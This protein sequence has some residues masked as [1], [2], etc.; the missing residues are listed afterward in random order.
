MRLFLP[1]AAALL[2]ASPTMFS[3][4]QAQGS[5]SITGP[6]L[7]SRKRRANSDSKSNASSEEKRGLDLIR[8][9]NEE[10]LRY[11]QLTTADENSLV[12]TPG[13]TLAGAEVPTEAPLVPSE[14]IVDVDITCTLGGSG[15]PCESLTAPPLGICVP[16]D[17]SDLS[18]VTFEFQSTPCAG[19]DNDQGTDAV[20]TDVGPGVPPSGADVSIVCE[21]NAEMSAI[22]LTVT[23]S[24]GITA[25]DTFTVEEMNGG[26][27]PLS[28]VC[29]IS[30][31]GSGAVL[32]TN[33]FDLSGDVSLDLKDS[34]GSLILVSCN[35]VTCIEELNVVYNLSNVGPDSMTFL[36]LFR[37]FNGVAENLV[38]QVTPNPL[39][40]GQSTSV[41]EEFTID[42]CTPGLFRISIAVEAEPANGPV[43]L[44][45]DVIEFSINER[46]TTPT[47]V[48]AEIPTA[49]PVAPTPA[50]VPATPAPVP[51]TPAPVPAT[52]APVPATPA[53]VPATPA[54]VP[55]TPAPVAS[56]TA[57][58]SV[59]VAETPTF[60]PTKARST[61]APSDVGTSLPTLEGGSITPAP[62]PGATALPTAESIPVT[63]TPGPTLAI[64]EL[65]TG[66]PTPAP[67][68][69]A[70]P[71]P[72]VPAT[73]APVVPATPAP[74][75]PAT[76]APVV[77]ATPAPVVPA[78]PAPVVPPT[79]LPTL[80]VAEIP[81]FRPTQARSTKAPSDVG[82]SLPTLEGGSIT[83][84]PVPGATALPTAESIPVTPTPG[85]TLAIVELPTGAPTPAPVVPATPAP[86]VP[87]TPAPVV[88]AT[89]APV[90]PATPAPVVPATPAPVVPAT[91][92]PVASPTVL[93]TLEVAEIPTFR[94]TKARSTK[95][96]VGVGTTLP[97]LEGGS[98]T[99]APFGVV[100]TLPTLGG[101]SITP[102]P[103]PATTGQPVATILPTAESIPVTPTPGPT[104]VS[105]EF[106]TGL[107]TFRPTKARSTKAPTSTSQPTE[108]IGGAEV[109]TAQPVA[110][111]TGAPVLL[112]TPALTG[113]PT[114]GPSNALCLVEVDIE[115]T[116][117][118]TGQPCSDLVASSGGICE[119]VLDF[120]YTFENVGPNAFTVTAIF[121]KFNTVTNDIVDQLTPN[122]LAAGVMTTISE[123]F[124]IDVCIPNRVYRVTLDAEAEP[125]NGPFCQ[126]NDIYEF[127]IGN[128]PT[129]APTSSPTIPIGGAEIPT[130]LP[131]F[132][133]T[134]ARSTKTPTS[135]PSKGIDK[136]EIPTAVPVVPATPAPVVPATPAPVVPATPAPVVPATPAPVVPATS[137]PTAPIGGA[138]L[139]SAS[140]SSK[141]SVPT[142]KGGVPTVAPSSKGSPVVPATP[143]PVVPATPAPVVPAT[144]APV[145]PATSLPTAPIGG[146][147][148]PSASPSSKGST[149]TS[150]GGV[151][152]SKGSVPTPSAKTGVPTSK[153]DVPT[154]G[155]DVTEKS[156]MPNPKS[157]MPNPKS[158]ENSVGSGTRRR[159]R[160]L[161]D[162]Q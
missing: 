158:G 13:P 45:D 87:A 105:A 95:G 104:L 85:P 111:P 89:P 75:V 84:A 56:P 122:P 147:E 6:E 31:T 48:V 125:E 124:T 148:L 96:P 61:K 63:P 150:K 15:L 157:G 4:A 42:V 50:P 134:K 37:D 62:V 9:Y 155:I 82:T 59:D 101:G 151:P 7:A 40:P 162:L 68:V 114:A 152:T 86:V 11:L 33:T 66:A 80:E 46:P 137:L 161:R 142:S 139:P 112:P 30:D 19:G 110:A 123:S 49:A 92:A 5:S 65:P 29:T 154:S 55:A 99:P 58:P 52:P 74:V 132:R 145:V 76:P 102:A 107:P 57:L 43:C 72:V 70:T 21:D 141:G 18:I 146:A 160:L 127:I 10:L 90:V 22:V 24:S 69:P 77:P 17:G 94:P 27:L 133:P 129:S 135:A 116:V 108:D 36:D 130:S 60:R 131:T 26:P 73:P 39:L 34:F 51:A 120:V 140:P 93:P 16:A 25:G 121:R 113:A 41:S 118:G 100:T 156:G 47:T 91:P 117:N 143:A 106:P 71:A 32:Q 153:G 97:T 159:G 12:P 35:D 23:P 44:A 53:P 14:C 28:M 138:E 81:T 79:V 109:P 115:C 88:P 78:T 1:T 64:V 119:V 8:S 136:A 126:D 149:P 20:C 3:G 54:P 2:L 38:S 103:V 67:V 128:V 98:T 144:P 83:P